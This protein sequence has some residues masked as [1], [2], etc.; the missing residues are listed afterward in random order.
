MAGVVRE[1]TA[2]LEAEIEERKRVEA[3]EAF[4]V[5]AVRSTNDAMITT[6]T[7]GTITGWNP[8]A[9]RMFGFSSAEATG[10]NISMLLAAEQQAEHAGMMERVCIG[11][12]IDNFETTRTTQDGRRRDLS[13]NMSPIVGERGET[14][15][16]C[17]IARD[18][19]RRKARERT[20]LERTEELRR[21]NAE[22]EQFAYVAS[23][24]LQEPLRMV[25]SYTE[26][27]GE[28]YAGQ[29]DARADKYIGY[30]VDGAKRMQRL[31]NDLLTY[32][33]VGRVEQPLAATD[34]NNVVSEILR[35]L[36]SAIADAD[37]VVEV[38]PLPVVVADSVQIGQVLQNLIGNA[39]KFRAARRMHVTVGANRSPDGWEFHVADNGI[40]IDP[41]YGERIFQMF[42]RLHGRDEYE[43]N[44][45]GL[46]IAKKIVERHGGRIWFDSVPGEGTTFHFTIPSLEEKAA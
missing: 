18:V 46:T 3:R 43:G 29:I 35:G 10:K 30:A 13:Y 1:R 28:R 36:N 41:R 27:L 33:R 5:A 44:G 15:G 39:L 16:V 9:E 11:E 26:L 14:A 22:L 31:V 21:S 4:Y 17:V 34:M 45:I 42:Q 8:A 24:D 19:T 12:R 40:G 20:L 2:S 25:A 6:R 37:A 23:H 38:L 7:D 32:S